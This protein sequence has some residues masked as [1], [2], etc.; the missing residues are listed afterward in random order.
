[1][2]HQSLGMLYLRLL[3]S[4]WEQLIDLQKSDTLSNKNRQ[5]ITGTYGKKEK[6][7]TKKPIISKYQVQFIMK[8]VK[9]SSFRCF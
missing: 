2:K 6:K 3:W 4:S 8:F 9:S 5:R 1:M 7:D